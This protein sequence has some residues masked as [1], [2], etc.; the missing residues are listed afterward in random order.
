MLLES[1]YCI[2]DHSRE[3]LPNQY[4]IVSKKDKLLGYLNHGI[5]T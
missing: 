1:L 3:F 4:E 5:L 2:K